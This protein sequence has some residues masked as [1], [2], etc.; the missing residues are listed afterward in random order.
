MSAW[1]PSPGTRRPSTPGFI[2]ALAGL[3]LLAAAGLALPASAAPVEQT[4]P[5]SACLGCH[6]QPDLARTLVSGELLPLTID[7]RLFAASVH[8]SAQLTCVD[9]HTAIT[10]YPH[11]NLISGDLRSVALEM[12]QVCQDC[13]QEQSD[14]AMD[15][16]HQLALEAGNRNAAVCSDCHNPHTQTRLRD[17]S[18]GEMLPE[19]R[20][21]IPETCAQCHSA[22]YDQ[23][24]ASIHGSVLFE[25][26]NTH[27]PT[28]TDCHGVHSIDDPGTAAFRLQSPQLCAACHT[29]P[30]I[31]DQYGL[32]TAV[33]STYVAD[34]HGT[35]VTL[36]EQRHPE[37]FL[38]MPVC[39]DCHGVHDIQRTDDPVYGIAMKENLLIACQQCHPDATIN[40]PDAWMSHYIPS[41]QNYP[42]VYYVDLFYKI[43]IPL[44]IGGMSIFVVSDIVRRLIERRKGTAH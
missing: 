16:V 24:R 8:G 39:F 42:L 10:R 33:L 15:S 20:L 35:T 13:H 14:Q 34:F 28:C 31:M 9:C 21:H 18:T 11:G 27:V 2:A 44:V 30:E 3:V 7:D 22:I 6:S 4:I 25:A 5:S 36:F 1:L 19:A 41:P 37:Q 12:S 23:Y 32:S 29:D 40:F 17:A 38:N 43:L 26:G